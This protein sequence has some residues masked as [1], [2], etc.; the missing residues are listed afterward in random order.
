[1]KIYDLLG[2]E[3]VTLVN[4]VK[5]AGTY[6]VQF[7]AGNLSSGMYFCRLQADH[8]LAVSKLMLIK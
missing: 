5:S 7:N 8:S 1:M 4:E 2:R 3:I 6:S